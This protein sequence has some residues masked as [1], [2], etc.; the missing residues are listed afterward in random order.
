MAPFSPNPEIR[1]SGLR[2]ATA[3]SGPR[4]PDSADGTPSLGWGHGL[5]PANLLGPAA[6][7]GDLA[8][9]H[10]GVLL[11]GH[12]HHGEPA[13]ELLGLDEGPVGERQR[14]A[15][16]VGAEGLVD[17][18]HEPAGEHVRAGGL[19]LVHDRPGER[20]APAKPLLAVVAHPLLVEVDEVLGH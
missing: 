17:L 13:E 12:I 8:G 6:G 2:P 7:L 14:A 4:G 9:P 18:L 1:W 10:P 20:P 15:G 3:L 5:E 11:V 16:G 19:D